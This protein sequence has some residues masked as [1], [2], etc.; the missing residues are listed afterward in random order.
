MKKTL[1][2]VAICALLPLTTAH[3]GFDRDKF[4]DKLAAVKAKVEAKIDKHAFRLKQTYGAQPTDVMSSPVG[5]V[6]GSNGN[7]YVSD[8][9]N[10]VLRK[11]DADGNL[12]QVIASE[13]NAEGQLNGPMDISFAN[14]KIYVPELGAKRVSVFDEDGNLVQVIGAGE[15][16]GPRGVWIEENGDVTV[17]D[18][19]GFRVVKYDSAGNYLSECDEGLSKVGYV[20][21]IIK[22]N[23][24]YLITEATL[25]YVVE[26]DNDCNTVAIH[27]SYGSGEGQYNLPRGINTDGE[28]IYVSD[29]GNARVQK[30]D[31]DMNYVESIGTGYGQLLAPNQIIKHSNG[32]YIVTSTSEHL[33]KY[34]NPAA[35]DFATATVGTPRT[36]DGQ[37]SNPSGMGVDYK[38]KELYVADAFNH[39]IQ[40]FDLKSGEY[41]R[42]FGQLG[43]G[44]VNGDMLAPQD[45]H[46]DGDKVF[47]SNRFLNKISVFNKQ[48]EEIESFGSAGT[49]L[50]QFNQPYGIETDKDG[51]IYVVDFGNNRV[52]KFDSAYTPLWATSGFGF[53][54]GAMWAPIRVDV[55]NDGRVFVADAYNNQ[56]QVLDAE[57][58]EYITKFGS[59]GEGDGDLSL[60]FGVAIDER[61][62]RIL[63]TEV[64]N[65]RISIFKLSDYSFVRSGLQIGGRDKDLFFPYEITQCTPWGDFCTSNAVG[66]QI[67]RWRIIKR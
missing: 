62:Q 38:A 9:A 67:Q 47:V 30:F 51:N 7:Y 29:S 13:G 56:I 5:I 21:D 15:L 20:D 12:L 1:L 35:P 53:G 36:G 17:L 64:A 65:N 22:V 54:A 48:G 50:G 31:L 63:V 8:L 33:I 4:K 40:V 46:V 49:A 41:K 18:E 60:P 24:N 26:V 27:G 44:F 57:T 6:E 28:F 2:S 66:N 43:F 23:G 61:T 39:R 32:S 19:F 45:A 10:G 55:S 14:G 11:F 25:G 42:Q 37:L 3:A 34:F 59:F 58:G 52:Q 16:K